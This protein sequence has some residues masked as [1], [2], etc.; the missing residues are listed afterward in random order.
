ML[1]ALGLAVRVAVVVWAAPRFPPVED[2][3]FYHQLATRIAAGLGYTWQWPDG[4]VTFVAHYPVGYPALVAALYR[5]FGAS[6]T[7]A[8]TLN[9]ALGALA[10]LGLHRLVAADAGRLAAGFAAVTFALH[11]AAVFYTPAL[12]TEGVTAALLVLCAFSA[13]RARAHDSWWLLALAG[14]LAGVAILVRGQ[15]LLLLPV[16]VWL[17]ARGVGRERPPRRVLRGFVLVCAAALVVLPWTARNC[18]R[19]DRCVVVSA[20]VGWNL[21]IGVTPGATGTFVPITGETVPAECRTVFGEAEKDRCFTSAA[22]RQIRA[23]PMRWLGLIPKKL[24]QTF[25]YCGAAGWYLSVSGPSSFSEQDKLRLGVVETVWQRTLLLLA[26]FGVARLPGALRRT[27]SALSALGALAS[28]LP[29]AWV[30]HVLLCLG[31]GLVGRPI[32]RQPSIVASATVV[33]L[34]AAT[35]AA[36]FGA[37]RY[38]LVTL[39]FVVVLG[40]SALRAARTDRDGE[41]ES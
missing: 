6:P 16:F 14:G 39:P 25:E 28:L 38:S 9:A 29:L 11:P 18:Q 12:M 13:V 36:F 26:L 15:S 40:A 35:H 7:V 23:A 24:A 22:L 37:G 10:V 1:F 27:R 30:A 21:L 31:V 2:A 17:A 4:V 3:R 8:M 34:T 5:G 20:N 33:A 19:M 32:L 41:A